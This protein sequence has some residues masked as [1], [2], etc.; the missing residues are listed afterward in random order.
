V[1]FNTHI[2]PVPGGFLR[3]VCRH[4]PAYPRDIRT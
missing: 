4:A 2:L 1:V 3:A